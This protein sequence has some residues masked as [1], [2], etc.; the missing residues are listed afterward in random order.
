M[1]IQLFLFTKCFSV[2]DKLLVKFENPEI[3]C[4]SF[5]HFS[6]LTCEGFW[7]C[8]FFCFH[9]HPSHICSQC[10]PYIE[11]NVDIAVFRHIGG[12]CPKYFSCSWSAISCQCNFSACNPCVSTAIKG[13]SPR[14]YVS[15]IS[16]S[17][18]HISLR[19]A[20]LVY[21]AW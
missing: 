7:M 14:L 2:Y 12:N 9:R 21:W 6:L 16:L 5:C 3:G 17:S 13:F 4:S 19:C 10:F 11:F 15:V 20:M 1:N 18:T 8:F